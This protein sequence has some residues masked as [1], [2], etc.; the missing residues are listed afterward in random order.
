MKR[1]TLNDGYRVKKINEKGAKYNLLVNA[2]IGAKDHLKD[3]FIHM[4][5]G[6]LHTITH[7]MESAVENIFFCAKVACTVQKWLFSSYGL[8]FCKL[9]LATS[10]I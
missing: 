1:K 4:I 9:N 2:A 3:L 7:V 10:K 5:W 8:L 6:Y